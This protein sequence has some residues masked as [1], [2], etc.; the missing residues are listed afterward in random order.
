TRP[1]CIAVGKGVNLWLIGGSMRVLALFLCSLVGLP[2]FGQSQ[3][4]TLTGTVT[5]PSGAATPNAEIRLVNTETGERYGAVANASGNYTLPLVKPGSYVLTCE[6]SGFK[7]RRES[8]I[9]LETGQ[10]ARI[11]IQLE[12]GAVSESTT[13]QAEAP[14]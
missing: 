3:L 9:V 2:L 14:L 11:D 7:Q 10:Q 8:G 5:D 12:I 6:L 13:V 1:G 4:A